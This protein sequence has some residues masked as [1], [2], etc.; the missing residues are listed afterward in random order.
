MLSLNRR[1]LKKKDHEN[2]PV[3]QDVVPWQLWLGDIFWK[4]RWAG[5]KGC[6]GHQHLAE[7]SWCIRKRKWESS[8]ENSLITWKC[9]MLRCHQRPGFQG[10]PSPIKPI[11]HLCLRKLRPRKI[12]WFSQGHTALMAKAGFEPNSYVL[13]R[14]LYMRFLGPIQQSRSCQSGHRSGAVNSEGQANRL[15]LYVL[16][17]QQLEPSE[18]RAELQLYFKATIL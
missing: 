14:N 12:Q 2:W 4:R 1:H 10:R 9:L 17:L 15:N 3:Q 7:T 18:A 11:F 8:R 16:T 13:S 5:D 6:W